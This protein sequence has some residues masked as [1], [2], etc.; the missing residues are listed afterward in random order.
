VLD[1]GLSDAGHLPDDP[2]FHKSLQH[3]A[4]GIGAQCRRVIEPGQIPYRGLGQG[5]S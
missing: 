3:Q 4:V 1:L 2:R 5:N